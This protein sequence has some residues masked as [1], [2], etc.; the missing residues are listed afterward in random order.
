LLP[1]CTSTPPAPPAERYFA[2]AKNNLTAMDYEAA[3]KNLDRAVKSAGADPAGRQA[4]LLHTAL[5][6]ALAEGTKEM[7][8][9]YGAGMRQPAAS[10]RQSQFVKMRADY[11]GICRVRL[12][13]AMENMLAERG[14]LGEQLLPFNVA[15]PEFRG[16]RHPAIETIETGYGPEEND[17]YRAELESVRNALARTLARWAGAGEDV[18]KG[19]AAYDRGGVQIDPRVLLI[20]ASNSFLRIGEVFDRR[21]LDDPRHYRITLEVV[22]DTL[23]VALKLLTAKPDKELEARA[24]KLRADCEKILKRL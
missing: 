1:A 15:F 23:D 14:K 3:L 4:R 24:K 2:D 9:A 8:D 10:A 16:T 19:H 6:V 5:L 17:R 11:Y 22:R 12:M 18:H 20:E 7:G 21:S 13:N